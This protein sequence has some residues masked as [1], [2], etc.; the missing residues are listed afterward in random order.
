MSKIVA[1]KFLVSG[2]VQ[3]VAF[4]WFVL[5]AAE[6][7]GLTGYVRNLRDGRVEV[8]AEGADENVLALRQKLAVGPR[9][10]VV[11]DLN[12]Q[13]LPPSGRWRGFNVTY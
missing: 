11:T 7:L 1:R 4:R 3:G 5:Q 8:L 13:E 2:R 12:E 10:A 6:D 9:M